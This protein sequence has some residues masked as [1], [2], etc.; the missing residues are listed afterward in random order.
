[1][2]TID[3]IFC[4]AVDIESP[5]AR[6]TYLDDACCGDADVRRRVDKLLAA[7]FNGAGL[8]DAPPP[9][10]RTSAPITSRASTPPRSTAVAPGTTVDGRYRL[11]EVIGEG[12]MG[13][14][15]KAEQTQPVRRTVALKLIKLGM[16]TRRSSRASRPSG[17]RW[18][19]MDHPNV[20]A[21]VR[22]RRDRHRPARTS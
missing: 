12:G 19:L 11:L 6:N 20:A 18:R 14:V 9:A 17:R 7:H 13:V 15:Y 5:Q 3:S 21:R 16:D 4:N 8:L 22:R 10:C 2:G 1:M